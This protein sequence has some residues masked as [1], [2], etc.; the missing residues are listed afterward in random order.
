M[1]ESE[2]V[3]R[4]CFLPLLLVR[5]HAQTMVLNARDDFAA[6]MEAADERFGKGRKGNETARFACLSGYKEELKRQIPGLTSI[7]EGYQKN[8]STRDSS[9]ISIDFGK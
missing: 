7:Y 4:G 2:R 8:F 6:C 1:E 3:A 9:L 5:R